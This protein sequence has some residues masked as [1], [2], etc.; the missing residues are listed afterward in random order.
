MR[1][2]KLSRI[3]AKVSTHNT[4]G[5][6]RHGERVPFGEWREMKNMSSEHAPALSVRA[7]RGVFATPTAAAGLARYDTL[8]YVDGTDLVVNG[9]HIDL[10]LTV[11]GGMKQLIRMGAYVIVMPDKRYVNLADLTDC[12]AIEAHVT[13]SE[14][15]ITPCRAD[16]TFY[17][18]V[19]VSPAEPEK[20]A[21][22]ES[23]AWLDTS[24]S[25]RALLEYSAILNGWIELEKTY[26]RVRA[27]NIGAPFSAGDGVRFSG[28][29]DGADGYYTLVHCERD[30]LVIAA[31]PIEGQTL[32][33]LTLAREM[34]EMDFVTEAGNRLWGCRYGIAANGEPVNEIYASAL[35]D[36][37]NWHVFDGL[38][39]DAYVCGVGSDGAFTGAVTYLGTPVFFKERFLHRVAGSY[40]ATYQVVSTPVHGVKRGSE[41]SIALLGD[42]L[43]YHGEDGVYL[44]DGSLPRLVSAPLGTRRFECAAAG[45]LGD[46][47]YI[48]MRDKSD[49]GW[50]L[51][52]FDAA[53]S[54]WHREDD[55]RAKCFCEVRGELYFIDGTGRILTVKG[56][57]TPV[58]ERVP[59]LVESGVIGMDDPARRYL[60][61]LHVRMSLGA[62]ARVTIS[63]QYDSCGEFC[64]LFSTRSRAFRGYTAVLRPRR[65]DHLRLRIEGEGDVKIFAVTLFEEGGNAFDA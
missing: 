15:E 56:R 27:A 62:G 55:T 46:K 18:R 42:A 34:P 7:P 49:D 39:S 17:T 59:F 21:Q 38:A 61:R 6:Y 36:F 4:F 50:N 30:A 9:A 32:D 1:F 24:R 45:A 5:G 8:L 47:Y 20:P 19:T 22:G 41:E 35:G 14:V 65:C 37:R 2:P 29:P 11:D 12:G 3:S 40:P 58:E 10:S 44:Y 53:R 31:R 43:L 25:P 63:A 48:S 28:L 60:S 16:G 23:V 33:T 51:F 64:E 52:V 54:L 13:A 57:G 26:L